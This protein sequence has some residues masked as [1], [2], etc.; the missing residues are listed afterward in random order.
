MWHYGSLPPLL[1][2]FFT[3]PQW[4]VSWFSCYL[5]WPLLI[6][7]L[8]WLLLIFS[9]PKHCG[10]WSSVLG[11]LFLTT[12][13]PL[14]ISFNL[15]LTTLSMCWWPPNSYPQPRHVS[16][17][18]D[19]YVQLGYLTTPCRYLTDVSKSCPELNSLFPPLNLFLPVSPSSM[20]I[21]S[22]HHVFRL[23]S[24]ASSLTPHTL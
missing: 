6:S 16:W 4:Y 3:W 1:N 20:A 22:F 14:V 13:T 8:G 24:L 19:V 12:F 2:S 15:M 9:I 23:K 17:T 11:P 10:P 18:L 7:V 21:I 5:N